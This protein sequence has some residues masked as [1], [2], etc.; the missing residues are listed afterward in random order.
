METEELLIQQVQPEVKS[1]ESLPTLP[2]SIIVQKPKFCVYARVSIEEAVNGRI[3]DPELQLGPIRAQCAIWGYDVVGE[4]IDRETGAE[5]N[6]SQFRKMLQK[7]NRQEA[8]GIVVWKLDRLNR[9]RATDAMILIDEFK[10]RGIS[11]RSVTESWVDTTG[12]NPTASLLFFISAWISEQEKRNISMR[13]KAGISNMRTCSNSPTLKHV[14]EAGECVHCHAPAEKIWKGGR[15]KGRADSMK[16]KRR[17]DKKPNLRIDE[18]F[19]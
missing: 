17:W 8:N 10:Q 9:F 1:S 14:L 5:R 3:Q 12:E 19:Y 16:R 7:L 11:L 15:P 18:L 4:F 13:V 6:R 2:L